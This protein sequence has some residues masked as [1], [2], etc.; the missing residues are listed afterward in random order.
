MPLADKTALVTGATQGLGL[1]VA[2]RLAAEGCHLVLSGFA[3]AA[4]IA[5]LRRDIEST[6]HV[7]TIHDDGDLARPDAIER[8]I[9]TATDA[10]GAIDIVVNNAVARHV[11]PIE[12]FAT[13]DW[14]RDLAVN[15]SAAFH[16]IRLTLSGM[17][18]RNWGR[19]VNV[20]SI[21]G[22][23]G[24][25]NRV[26]Y[27]TTKTALI[28][29][30]RAAALETT[31]YDITCNAVCPGTSATP[32]HETSLDALMQRTGL[33]RAEAE[34]QL[35]AGKQPTGRL[36]SPEGVAALIA[37]LCGPGSRD[38]TGAVLPIDGGW[39]AT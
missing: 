11:N 9:A 6:H 38:I 34:R 19:I 10:F 13:V 22:L 16:T 8:L 15:L 5:A 14:D 39:S 18:Q 27:V 29:L 25:P 21:Y 28:G 37:F 32:V 7:R 36:I 30:T 1:A 26:G 35:L 20:S 3:D 12:S 17:K 33:A 23:V 31:G 24:A 4:A 2:R